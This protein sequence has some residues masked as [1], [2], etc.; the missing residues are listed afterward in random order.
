M[1]KHLFLSL[2]LAGTLKLSAQSGSFPAVKGTSLDNKQVSIPLNNGKYSVVAIAFHR[3]AEEALKKWLNPMYETFIPKKKKAGN[4]D[5]S[6]FHDVN[7]LFIPMINGF[8]RIA[9][10]FKSGTDKEF[11]PYIIDTEKTDIK[12]LQKSLGVSNN[13]IPYFFVLDKDGKIVEQVSGDYSDEKLEKLEES[14]P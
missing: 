3:D 8:K 5:M 4:F 11:W 14:I 13:K 7:F 10:E 9:D 6:D 2:L 1:L 12:N